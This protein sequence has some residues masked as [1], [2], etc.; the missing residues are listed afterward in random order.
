MEHPAHKLLEW[1]QRNRRDLPWRRT[2]DAYAI[3]VSE[4][5]LQQTQVDTVIPYFR[6]FM[7]EYPTVGALARADQEAVVKHWQGLGYYSRARRLHSAAQMVVDEF[8]GRV[9]SSLEQIRQLPGVGAYT[10]GAVLSIA[11]DL[12]TPA[13]DGNVLRVMARYLGVREPVRQASVLCLIEDTMQAWIQLV[14]PGEFTQAVMELGALVCTPRNAA[15]LVCPLV[16]SCYAHDLGEVDAIPAKTEKKARRKANVGALWIEK[17]GSIL[18]ER[19][20]PSGL[21]AGMW[22]LPAVEYNGSEDVTSHLHPLLEELYTEGGQPSVEESTAPYLVPMATERHLFSHVEWS[23]TVYRPV[24]LTL[25]LGV[26]QAST[27]RMWCSLADLEKLAWPRVYEKLLE[28][29]IGERVKI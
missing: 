3:L 5:M 28:R 16:D 23:V 7:T 2:K 25:D 20:K 17:N 6:R 12:P 1:Y 11:Y 27:D 21:L 29:L 24:G 15:C 18:V 26:A 4:T 13:I 8:D 9:P 10:A 19:R 22:Q 14:S